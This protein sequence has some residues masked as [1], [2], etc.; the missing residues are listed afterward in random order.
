MEC[1][2][3]GNMMGG[4]ECPRGATDLECSFRQSGRQALF[5]PFTP[6]FATVGPLRILEDRDNIHVHT[7]RELAQAVLRSGLH[8]WVLEKI[9]S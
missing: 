7:G 6:N 9:I 2:G 5:R 8:D 3:D 1:D 4:F